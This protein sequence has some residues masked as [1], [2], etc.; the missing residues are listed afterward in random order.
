MTI[1]ISVSCHPLWPAALAMRDVGRPGRVAGMETHLVRSGR[2]RRRRS[3]AASVDILM[4]YLE[5]DGI[6]LPTSSLGWWDTM[7]ALGDADLAT[8]ATYVPRVVGGDGSAWKELVAQLEPLLIQLL[9]RSRTLGPMR[10]NLDDC[11]A[12]MRKCG[13]HRLR[14]SQI[15]AALAVAR[16]LDPVARWRRRASARVDFRQ[17]DVL[18]LQPRRADA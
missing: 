16:W 14:G 8:L 4:G 10:H 13:R 5:R 2:G 15:G 7:T 1:A 11:R 17:P 9:R 12:V 6:P 18:R 3:T